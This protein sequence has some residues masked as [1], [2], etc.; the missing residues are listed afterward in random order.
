[1]GLP[2][3][4]CRHQDSQSVHGTSDTQTATVQDVSVDHRRSYIFVSEELLHSTDVISI[5]KKMSGK[6]VTETYVLSGCNLFQFKRLGQYRLY[7]VN[8][9]GIS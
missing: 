7:R 6:R 8:S 9:F 2:D 5:F 3:K 1:M 4:T